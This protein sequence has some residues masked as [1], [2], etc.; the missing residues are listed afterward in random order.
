[1]YCNDCA[2]HRW[3]ECGLKPYDMPCADYVAKN[4]EVKEMIEGKTSDMFP[5]RFLKASDITADTQATIK[6][7]KTEEISGDKKLIVVFDNI[8]KGLVCNKTNCS[9]IE[10]IVGSDVFGDWPGTTVT[11]YTVHVPFK[12]EDVPAIRI[13]EA[14]KAV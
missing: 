1:M 5:S 13:K 7:V 4:M 8:E 14:V 12:G 6:D 11:L 3:R 9:R 2:R 10:K